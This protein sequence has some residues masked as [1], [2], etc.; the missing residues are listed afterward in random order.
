MGHARAVQRPLSRWMMK[1]PSTFLVAETSIVSSVLEPTF[2]GFA[3]TPWLLPQRATTVAPLASLRS[4]R[5]KP[6]L[7]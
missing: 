7:P 2:V 6:S 5:S 1:S 3:R 4:S